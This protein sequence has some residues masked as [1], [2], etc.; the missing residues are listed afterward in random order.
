[1]LD[2][3]HVALQRQERALVEGVEGREEN[4][5]LE[6]PVVEDSH[7]R[8]GLSWR[9][10]TADGSEHTPINKPSP[11]QGASARIDILERRR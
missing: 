4:A 6:V 3:L 7:G 2:E 10:R 9:G 8:S 5:G 11:A 1:M